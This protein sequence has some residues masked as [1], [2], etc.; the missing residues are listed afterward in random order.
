VAVAGQN[1]RPCREQVIRP[2]FKHML[3]G[4]SIQEYNAEYSYALLPA[5]RRQERQPKW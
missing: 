3:G 2:R 4:M 1:N 5:D